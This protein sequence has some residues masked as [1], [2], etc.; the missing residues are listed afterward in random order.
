MERI[1]IIERLKKEVKDY[2]ENNEGMIKEIEKNT[3]YGIDYF[4]G[5]V[6]DA[7]E[8]GINHGRYLAL[9]DIVNGN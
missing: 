9:K 4:G 8:S 3:F 7:F 5:N 2:E 6:D 1:K